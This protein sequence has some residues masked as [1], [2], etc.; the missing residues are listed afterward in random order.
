MLRHFLAVTILGLFLFGILAVPS[1]QA[2][3][4]TKMSVYAATDQYPDLPA[5]SDP[6]YPCCNRV[7]WAFSFNRTYNQPP[8]GQHNTIN[9]R[10]DGLGLTRGYTDLESP[11]YHKYTGTEVVN[12]Q[13]QHQLWIISFDPQ[14]TGL[15]N[16]LGNE[17]NYWDYSPTHPDPGP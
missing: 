5:H 6:Y 16:A 1:A 14:I 17:A 8:Y 15:F 7:N 2:L 11:G 9:Y 13:V 4:K 10:I 12:P 3:P